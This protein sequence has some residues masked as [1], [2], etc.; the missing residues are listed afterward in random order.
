MKPHFYC[1]VCGSQVDAHLDACPQCRVKFSGV[2]CP[3]CLYQGTIEQFLHGCP[4]CGYQLHAQA[5]KLNRTKTTSRPTPKRR[6]P[7]PWHISSKSLT[8]F[9]V[10]LIFT[11]FMI[12]FIYHVQISRL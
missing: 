7:Y 8:I 1:D 3:S 11:T 6:S 9:A 10:A 12:L 4:S 2:R 5:P